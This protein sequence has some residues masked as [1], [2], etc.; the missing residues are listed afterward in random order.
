MKKIM[1]VFLLAVF[2]VTGC[3]Q[4]PEKPQPEQRKLQVVTTMFAAY[5]FARQVAGDGAQVTMLIPPGTDIHAYEPTP[6]DIAKLQQC[7][8]LVCVGGESDAWVDKI[9]GSLQNKKLQQIKMLD[10]V[11]PVEEE[12]KKGMTAH[13]DHEDQAG[14]TDHTDHAKEYDEHVWT[15]PAN[16]MVIAEGLRDAFVTKDSKNQELYK[17]NCEEFVGQLAE[18]DKQFRTVV[19]QGK[20]K[21]II[22]G[23]RFPLRYFTDAYGLSYYAA[24]PGCAHNTE[25]S[26]STIAFLINKVKE[27][28][29]PVVFHVELSNE[30]IAKAI[31]EATG[32]QLREFNTCHNVPKEAF[33]REITYVELMK[34]NL[35]ALKE[36]LN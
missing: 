21:E 28:K 22:F 1:T 30:K 34:Q 32:A 3:S 26:A 15:S 2:L 17:K 23:D 5:D 12:L 9:V 29:I 11:K 25:A 10:M 31:C 20:R 16:A 27:E 13:E 35:S 4:A 7:D 19:A 33:D 18:L 6:K 8:I 14:H 36:A 24:F